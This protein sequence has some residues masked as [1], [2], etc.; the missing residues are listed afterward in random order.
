LRW[1]T[2]LALT[3]ACLHLLLTLFPTTSALLEAR[4]KP[5]PKDY[6]LIFGTVWGPDNVPIYGI[7]VSI[8]RADQKK[9]KWHVYTNRRGEFGQRVPV[10]KADYIIRAESKGVKLPNGKHLQATPQVTVHIDS[11]ERQDTGLHL[12]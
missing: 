11:N 6:V 7:E 12:Q 1:C 8:R 2:T 10:G 5:K 4:D 3:S 9:P